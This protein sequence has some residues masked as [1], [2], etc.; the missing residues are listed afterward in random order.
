MPPRWLVT[1]GTQAVG[2]LDTLVVGQ[3]LI[4]QQPLFA[5]AQRFLLENKEPG[6]G[7]AAAHPM[8]AEEEPTQFLGG[9]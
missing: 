2:G 6:D 8:P 4:L 5:R 9:M 1:R 7:T 3:A